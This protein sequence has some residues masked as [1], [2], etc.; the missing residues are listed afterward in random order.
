MWPASL[1]TVA[2]NTAFHTESNTAVPGPFNRMYS[3]SRIKFFGLAF[4]AMFVY[5]WFPGY[6]FTALSSFNWI[7]W[8][9]PNNATLNNI[10]GFNNGLG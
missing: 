5:F 3:M 4:L 6:L 9:A 7:S 2:L 8:I 1:V 10:V